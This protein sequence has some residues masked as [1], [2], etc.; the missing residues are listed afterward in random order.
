M[1]KGFLA[2]LFFGKGPASPGQAVQQLWAEGEAE[3]AEKPS[4]FIKHTWQEGICYPP[5]GARKV[6]TYRCVACGYLE[7]YTE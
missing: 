7:S 1:Q 5:T 2:D 6:V 4:W 3:K